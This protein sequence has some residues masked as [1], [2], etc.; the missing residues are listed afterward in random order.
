MGNGKNIFI[1]I[2]VCVIAL[3]FSNDVNAQPKI[4]S[5]VLDLIQADFIETQSYEL[6]GDWEF[7]WEHLYSPDNLDT[8]QL[9]QYRTFPSIWNDDFGNYG[10]ATYKLTILINP[11][12]PPLALSIPDFYSAYKLYVNGRE[13]ANNGKV[14]SS[15]ENYIPHW[16]S[17][18]ISL[19]NNDIDSLELVLQI[20][21]FDHSKGGPKNSII[22]GEAEHLFSTRELE[23]GYSY[24]L[25]G[26]LIMGGLFFFGLYLF[27]RHEKPLFYFS[28]FCLVYSYRII[29]FGIYP[30]HFLLPDIPWIITLK[31]EYITLFISG[32]LFGTY[33]LSLYPREASRM[34][35]KTLSGISLLFVAITLFLPASYF[36][37]LITPYFIAL[38]LYITYATYV[39]ILA[40]VHK[41]DGS[42]FSLASTGVIFFVFLH[43]IMVYFG[44]AQH[45]LLFNFL[46]YI[47]FF[48]FQSLVLSF[49]FAKYLKLAAIQAEAASK[50]KS[51]FL[52]TM[53]HEIRT[54][55]NAVIGLSGLLSDTSLDEKQSEFVSTIK[56]SG[57]NLLSIINNI[58]DYSKIESGKLELEHSEFNTREVVENVL[59]V[60]ASLNHRD[61]LEIVYTMDASV[62]NYLI[63]DVNRFQQVLVNLVGNALK[64]TEKGEIVTSL[65]LIEKSERN[66]LEVTISDTGIGIPVNRKNRLFQSFSQV[67]ASTTRKYGGTG[68]GLVISKKLVEAMGGTINVESEINKGT[69]FTFNFLVEKSEREIEPFKTTYF[70]GKKVFILDD[71][72]TNL[73]ILTKQ[74]ESQGMAVYATSNPAD[75]LEMI[76]TLGTFD[77]GIM[78]MQM[79]ETNGVE[80]TQQIRKKWSSIELPIILLSSIHE[81]SDSDAK[82]LFNLYLT[83][84]VKQ[85]QLIMNLDR[86]FSN[87]KQQNGKFTSEEEAYNKVKT[88]NVLLAEDN[89]INQKVAAKILERMGINPD[90]AINGYEAFEMTKTKA[91]DLIFMDMEMPIMDGLD[92]TIQIRAHKEILPKNPIIIA[93]TANAMQE[94][95]DRCIKA[96]MDD[97]L[98]KPI[99]LESVRAIVK[100]WFR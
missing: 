84:P 58:L 62:P 71:N 91:Y 89:L 4:E 66:F 19:T 96:G 90:I 76:P 10:F 77:F 79:P 93:M 72:H 35:I 55:L 61:N 15:K 25:T 87:S 98:T 6:D 75:I 44:L 78:D 86:L 42:L 80:V 57:E 68:L 45:S 11:K 5:G 26:A 100:H 65:K 54:P 48:F 22:L 14:G 39:F 64:F 23:L 41:R 38:I 32:Y 33:I 12:A 52:S 24:G 53:S 50:A 59:D 81:L 18:T 13:I 16:V 51:Q 1:Y 47:S 28:L 97:F 63:A 82:Y 34:V 92:S 69:T 74:C 30:L 31:L 70:K 9:K 17:K 95:R 67:D 60:I 2:L 94:D 20:S 8:L 40:A 46:G 49:R 27:G 3:I 29:G 88:I 43:E 99:T 36:T 7:Y 85:S 83:K 73:E 56:V 37:L 21:N